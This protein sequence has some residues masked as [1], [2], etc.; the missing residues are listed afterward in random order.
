MAD[1]ADVLNG[2]GGDMYKLIKLYAIPSTEIR[3]VMDLIVQECT[4]L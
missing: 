1:T 4:Q 2:G 3:L